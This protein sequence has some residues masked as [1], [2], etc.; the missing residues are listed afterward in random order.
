[1]SHL[2]TGATGNIG[3][4]VIERLISRGERPRVFVRDANKARARFGDRVTPFVGDLS[5]GGALARALAGV[6]VLFLVTDGPELATLDARAADAAKSAGVSRIVKLSSM[7]A[8]RRHAIGAWH[9]EG[10]DAITRSGVGWTFLQPVGF[11][12]NAL[13]WAPAIRGEGVVRASAGNGRLAMI[14][15]DDI[16]DVAVEV[17]T[18]RAHLGE[19]LP[20]TGPQTL[21]YADMIATI[22][23]ALG[24]PLVFQAISDDQARE[25]LLKRGM[26]VPV[27]EGLVTLWRSVRNGEIDIVSEGVERVLGRKPRSFDRWVQENIAAFRSERVGEAGAA[28]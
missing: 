24:R 4:R 13:A 11:M 25:A 8:R 19:S 7:D 26:P 1:M 10:E 22:G 15:P 5:D 20:L 6:E 16:A 9:A 23:K 14:H 17:L 3:G 28:P 21:T 2:V 18:K 27:V 12:S